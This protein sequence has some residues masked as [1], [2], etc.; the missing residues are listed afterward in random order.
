M[1]LNKLGQA[2]DCATRQAAPDA[3]GAE[4]KMFYWISNM[5]SEKRT[6]STGSA[7]ETS[8]RVNPTFDFWLSVDCT[9]S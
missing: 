8:N 1:Y 7:G 5:H 4:G 6:D 9:T 2:E 3:K